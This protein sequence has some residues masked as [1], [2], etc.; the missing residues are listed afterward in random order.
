MD[1]MT[2]P[3]VDEFVTLSEFASLV[4][5][6]TAAVSNWR[7]RNPKSF[8]LPVR[9]IEPDGLD[10]TYGAALLRG[11]L[12]RRAELLDWARDHGRLAQV[13]VDDTLGPLSSIAAKLVELERPT[14]HRYA[15]AKL[16][17]SSNRT[18]ISDHAIDAMAIV[19]GRLFEITL[20]TGPAWRSVPEVAPIVEVYERYEGRGGWVVPDL[21]NLTAHLRNQSAWTA[22]LDALRAEFDGIVGDRRWSESVELANVIGHVLDVSA[23]ARRTARCVIDPYCNTGGLLSLLARRRVDEGVPARSIRLIGR[24]I[25]PLR[26]AITYALL[27]AEGYAVEVSTGDPFDQK[28]QRKV[29][30]TPHSVAATLPR[31]SS[32]SDRPTVRPQ[33]GDNW[34]QLVSEQLQPTLLGATALPALWLRGPRLRPAA[35]HEALLN[36][37]MLLA[38]A[39]PSTSRSNALVITRP[40][41]ARRD[42]WPDAVLLVDL[43]G[44][45]AGGAPTVVS[46]VVAH[47]VD[48]T[49]LAEP[50]QQRAA[51]ARPDE[52]L[53]THSL[54]PPSPPEARSVSSGRRNTDLPPARISPGPGRPHTPSNDRELPRAPVRALNEIRALME[55]APVDI[56]STSGAESPPARS[57]DDALRDQQIVLV[58]PDDVSTLPERSRLVRLRTSTADIG[59][60]D[61]IAAGQLGDHDLP[62]RYLLFAVPFQAKDT[63][64]L[65]PEF[66]AGWCASARFQRAL[67][68]LLEGDEHRGSLSAGKVGQL[69][70][71]FPDSETCELVAHR[72]REYERVKAFADR[73]PGALEEWKLHLADAI[74]GPATED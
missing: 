62:G 70:A 64:G 37:S 41:A 24:D 23:T 59:Q 17:W 45:P 61:L 30:G 57:I 74:E 32:R 47:W 1:E 43:D 34:V 42:E 15:D 29:A 72:W 38:V 19:A 16:E 65:T 5:V 11:R 8:P 56:G 63:S 7:T 39:R 53:A 26:S 40:S 51:L 52:L 3:Q 28:W 73:L 10:P 12:F 33:S 35:A 50:L 13:G 6:T 46:E 68:A 44:L 9:N 60:V 22:T 58:H 67:R 21:T 25:D 20:G 69:P 14:P 36:Q 2:T 66:L 27:R 49:Q 54:E 71:D 31:S 55:S 18:D 48:G 4:G